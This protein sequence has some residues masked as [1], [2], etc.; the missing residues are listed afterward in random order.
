MIFLDRAPG[1]AQRGAARGGGTTKQDFGRKWKGACAECGCTCIV[2][3]ASSSVLSFATPG[4][5]QNAGNLHPTV[6]R[7]SRGDTEGAVFGCDAVL[8]G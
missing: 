8:V 6:P 2:W 5:R 1:A 7:C 4:H 3:L